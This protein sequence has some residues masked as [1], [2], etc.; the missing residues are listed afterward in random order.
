[1]PK[2]PPAVTSSL[3]TFHTLV[4][5]VQLTKYDQH[6]G[7]NIVPPTYADSGV[8]NTYITSGNSIPTAI[9]INPND[10]HKGVCGRFGF[11]DNVNAEYALLKVRY[12]GPTNEQQ[13][14]MGKLQR[15]ATSL[16][17]VDVPTISG[18]VTVQ[19][20]GTQQHRACLGVTYPVQYWYE[21]GTSISLLRLLPSVRGYIEP[22]NIE[23]TAALGVL[24]LS[25]ARR[26][27][28]HV[29]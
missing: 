29:Q 10:I 12:W 3:L 7:T 4:Y 26:G 18:G 11:K 22:A 17:T 21:M 27:F 14:P 28:P 15:E 2:D 5:D 16:L 1:M 9:Q 19:D 25:V 8:I 6:K 20:R 23:S 24:Y 13:Q